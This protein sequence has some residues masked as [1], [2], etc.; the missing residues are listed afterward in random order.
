MP[1]A[2]PQLMGSVVERYYKADIRRMPLSIVRSWGLGSV[3]ILAI[4]KLL[5][6]PFYS[7][8]LVP[9]ELAVN[10][11]TDGQADSE[12]LRRIVPPAAELQA[13]GFSSELLYTIPTIGPSRGL[14][15]AL[16]APGGEAVGLVV[17][18]VS[19][20]V[21]QTS[22]HLLSAE[23]SGALL[24][25]SS[26]VLRLPPVPGIDVIRLPAASA[27]ALAEAH[28]GRLHG[29]KLRRFSGSDIQPLLRE[30]QQRSTAYYVS[31]GLYVEASPE[32]IER[33]KRA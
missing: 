26:A 6:F 25:A 14:G 12:L 31:I 3:I 28:L 19:G 1:E 5:P 23:E 13:K 17:V 7:S 9:A 8:M 33:A 29:R 18:T 20:P 10:P 24:G 22:V 15:R 2:K 27:A 16:L 21:V 32:D 4:R 11:I 30:Q